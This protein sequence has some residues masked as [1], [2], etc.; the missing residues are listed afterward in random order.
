MTVS[1][2][3]TDCTL[4]H[5]LPRTR[6]PQVPFGIVLWLLLDLHDKPIR[7]LCEHHAP[8]VPDCWERAVGVVRD[9]LLPKLR[10]L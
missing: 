10:L 4:H 6:V 9:D 1:P 2:S 3:L 7:L 8:L 5:P